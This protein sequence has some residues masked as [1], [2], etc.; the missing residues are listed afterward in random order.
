MWI[1]TY[2]LA[3]KKKQEARSK[4]QEARS[5]LVVQ[6]EI[7]DPPSPNTMTITTTTTT[8]HLNTL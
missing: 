1:H 7:I 2:G 8:Y 6:N 5:K 3:P 4:K